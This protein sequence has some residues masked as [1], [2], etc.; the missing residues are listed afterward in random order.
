VISASAIVGL[1]SV[2]ALATTPNVV[3]AQRSRIDREMAGPILVPAAV[4]NL[5]EFAD[6]EYDDSSHVVGVVTDLDQDGH[7]DFII[8]S[9]ESLC[10]NAACG[11]L[12]IDGATLRE[13][14]ALNAGAIF[15]DPAA[16]GYPTLHSITS[17]S[18]NAAVWATYAYRRGT[19]RVVSRLTFTGRSLD[20]LTRSLASAG[21]RTK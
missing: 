20:S 13:V 11:W 12:I 2:V 18:A 8:R 7:P 17:M 19:Y 3:W 9:S 21:K 4:R 14:G 16:R 15:I 10:G 1:F 6:L 5:A